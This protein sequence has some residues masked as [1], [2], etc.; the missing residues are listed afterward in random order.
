MELGGLY[1]L[2]AIY[3]SYMYSVQMCAH[4]SLRLHFDIVFPIMPR[5]L[6]PESFVFY[7]AIKIERLKYT[8]PQICL[9]YTGMKL[10]L[11]Y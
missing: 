4:I 8:D 7:F 2:T 10:G 6:N 1:L 3:T 5:P 9:L 11:Y